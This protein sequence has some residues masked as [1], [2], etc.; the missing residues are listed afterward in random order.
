MHRHQI[1]LL[2]SSLCTNIHISDIN[3][4]GEPQEF[5][6]IKFREYKNTKYSTSNFSYLYQT[7]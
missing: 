3:C 1:Q 6:Y 4:S 2:L 7:L 5:L